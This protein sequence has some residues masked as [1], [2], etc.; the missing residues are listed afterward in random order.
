MV[1]GLFRVLLGSYLLFSALVYQSMH[2][3]ICGGLRVLRA[4]AEY[5]KRRP[6]IGLKSHEHDHLLRLNSFGLEDRHV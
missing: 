5:L 4:F 6:K 3:I 2:S 1:S